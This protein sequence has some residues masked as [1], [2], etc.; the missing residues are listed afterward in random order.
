MVR[1]LACRAESAGSIPVFLAKVYYCTYMLTTHQLIC[2]S[3]KRFAKFKRSPALRGN[4]QKRALCVKIFTRSPKKPN[5]AVRKLAKVK[6]EY[7]ATAFGAGVDAVSK[8]RDIFFTDVY[9]PGEGHN[10]KS[11]NNVLIRG[12][13]T[14]DLPGLKYKII[15]GALSCFGVIGRKT[16]RSQYGAKK[17]KLK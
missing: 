1:A 16:S 13:R 10:L 8:P 7:A 14:P 5:S 15:R 3:R 17:P 9:I 6:I 12:G 2:C 4:P 11:Q